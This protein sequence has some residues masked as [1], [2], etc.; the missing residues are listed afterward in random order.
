MSAL[1]ALKKPH[2]PVTAIEGCIIFA[3]NS[4]FKAE[5][6]E[7]AAEVAELRARISDLE[8]Q[9]EVY[10]GAKEVVDKHHCIYKFPWLPIGRKCCE[11]CEF[12][13][14]G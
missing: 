12:F 9:A 11:N 14:K 10:K 7:A 5:A 13:S 3:S 4:G 2:S 1:D 8:E 6:D